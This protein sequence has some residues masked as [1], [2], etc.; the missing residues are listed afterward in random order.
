VDNTYGANSSDG[1]R[2]G[3]NGHTFR[4]LVSSDHAEVG[5]ADANGVE[6]VRA[7]FDY[8]SPESSLASGYDALGLGGDGAMMSGDPSVVVDSTSSLDR[9]LNELGCVYTQDSPTA[10]ECPGWQVEVVY[11]MW[12]ALDAFGAE[13]YG[14]P[15]LEYV[16]ASPS[17]TTDTIYVTPGPCPP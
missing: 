11:E 1:Y 4:D 2:G 9:N 3:N 12:I 5:F 15:L 13:G 17:R 8:I 14:Y 6:R 7:K 16:H 10:A